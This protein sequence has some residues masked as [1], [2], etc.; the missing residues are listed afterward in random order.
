[1]R[2]FI[3]KHPHPTQLST[4]RWVADD[5]QAP[6][7][8]WEASTPEDHAAWEAAQIAAGWVPVSVGEPSPVPEQVPMHKLLKAAHRL[9]GIT[10]A[11]IETEIAALTDAA[12]RYEAQCDLRAPFVRRGAALIGWLAGRLNKTSTQIDDLFRYADAND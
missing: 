3:H 12:V 7:A 11:Q 4:R 6:A 2:L 8:P 5:A 9:H 1:M 10:I